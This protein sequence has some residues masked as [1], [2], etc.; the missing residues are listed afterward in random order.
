MQT[1]LACISV[2]TDLTI[3]VRSLWQV[4]NFGLHKL[5]KIK[6]SLNY[7][8]IQEVDVTYT[9]THTHTHRNPTYNQTYKNPKNHLCILWKGENTFQ[10]QDK[11]AKQDKT[12]HANKPRNRSL[13]T[14]LIVTLTLKNKLA[15][16]VL[17]DA[18]GEK[19]KDLSVLCQV[20]HKRKGINTGLSKKHFQIIRALVVALYTPQCL[21]YLQHP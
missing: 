11:L 16:S 9:Y 12:Q 17:T 21:A 14:K 7:S 2:E 18:S 13:A 3:N 1:V 5:Q 4:T 19:S 10:K 8:G 15:I 6:Q 20:A